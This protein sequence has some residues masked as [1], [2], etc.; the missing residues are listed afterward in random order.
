MISTPHVDWF[1]ISTILV[2]LGASFV[3]LLAAVLVPAPIR[4]PFAAVVS[5]LGFIG[6][7][8]T[9]VWL[10][11]SSA[12]GHAVISLAFERDRWTA[13][14]QVILCAIGLATSLVGWEHIAKR[15]DDHIAEFFSLLLASAAGMCFFVGS[16]NLMVMFL[17]L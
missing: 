7:L 14:A 11:V 1:S 13:L 15:N 3:A 8:V 5:S 2:L 12:D 6:G 10:Y 17:A 16:A 9:S 4:R